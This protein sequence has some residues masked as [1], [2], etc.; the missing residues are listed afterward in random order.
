MI[1]SIILL[2]IAVVLEIISEP[3]IDIAKD[4]C[5]LWYYKRKERKYKI[6]W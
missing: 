5:I 1:L 2:T 3:R 4:N 6:I